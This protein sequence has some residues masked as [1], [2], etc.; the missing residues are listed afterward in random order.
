MSYLQASSD[1]EDSSKSKHAASKD[2]FAGSVQ[3]EIKDL[4]FE[5]S[6]YHHCNDHDNPCYK[7]NGQCIK[8]KPSHLKMWASAIVRILLL[9]SFL[10]CKVI[11]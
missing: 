4:A 10:Q 3:D 8:M 5:L 11:Y 9:L 1:N 2:N 6:Q 7:V